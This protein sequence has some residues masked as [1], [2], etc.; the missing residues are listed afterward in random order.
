MIEV[1]NGNIEYAIRKLRKTFSALK[2]DLKKIEYAMSRTQRRR[3]K[4][5]INERRKKRIRAK[6]RD[7][8]KGDEDTKKYRRQDS[9]FNVRRGITSGLR[10]P[11]KQRPKEKIVVCSAL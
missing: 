5:R 8:D 4:D 2:A 10:N 9:N 7:R 3:L 6:M 1:R 11:L